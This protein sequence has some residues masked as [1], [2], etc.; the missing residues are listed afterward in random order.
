MRERRPEKGVLQRAARNAGLLL[1]G[2]GTAGLL[3]LATLVLATRGLGL[4]GFGLFA[5]LTAQVMLV[6]GIAA[7]VSNHAI[8]RYGVDHLNDNH[9][10]A[11]PET[12]VK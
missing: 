5:M 9:A 6:A 12:A 2:K 8:V 3:Q 4:P 11:D 1:T 10:R 7:F